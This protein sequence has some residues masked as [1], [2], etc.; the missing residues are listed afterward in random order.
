MADDARAHLDRLA[1]IP[2][3]F[4]EGLPPL[5]VWDFDEPLPAIKPKTAQCD[6]AEFTCF[7]CGSRAAA[8][9]LTPLQVFA[10]GFVL[11]DSRGATAALA[12]L[13]DLLYRDPGEA[14]RRLAVCGGWAC[15]IRQQVISVEDRM[16]WLSSSRPQSEYCVRT[17]Q[18][19]TFT[20]NIVL[21][22]SVS[23]TTPSAH[24]WALFQHLVE[25]S[26]FVSERCLKYHA[27]A[28]SA[29]EHP[30]LLGFKFSSAI[31]TVRA[32]E[33]F[34]RMYC[35]ILVW[36]HVTD[37]T[38][39]PFRWRARLRVLPESGIPKPA[40]ALYACICVQNI[41][42]SGRT[43][44]GRARHTCST[45]ATARVFAPIAFRDGLAACVRAAPKHALKERKD[46]QELRRF[47]Q[48]RVPDQIAAVAGTPTCGTLQA[49]SGVHTEQ[50]YY[51]A[52]RALGLGAEE[53]EE[54]LPL[55]VEK[56][57]CGNTV[58]YE[59]LKG[60]EHAAKA[61]AVLR[62]PTVRATTHATNAARVRAS[63]A[64]G[65]VLPVKRCKR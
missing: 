5:L 3:A 50:R 42:A 51:S 49:D 16:R 35:N 20:A 37:V 44:D 31:D 7:C 34:P 59:K 57:P 10:C 24:L 33:R 15:L 58:G 26:H 18:A 54:L 40:D 39:S 36:Q 6:P 32:M 4:N 17:G 8:S 11:D 22:H 1:A 45:H 25:N 43:T 63:E 55:F 27:T 65:D 62:M 64:C 23:K 21:L 28:L 48:G 19:E 9:F 46:A 53:A 60:G 41:R 61:C 47:G 2:R 29:T 14:H 30:E 56:L 12:S 38:L 52:L 13:G